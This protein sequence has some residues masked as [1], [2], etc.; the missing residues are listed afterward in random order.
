MLKATLSTAKTMKKRRRSSA[1]GHTWRNFSC[2]EE[3]K[4]TVSVNMMIS[5][6][7]T[8]AANLKNTSRSDVLQLYLYDIAFL[9]FMCVKVI[10]LAKISLQIYCHCLRLA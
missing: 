8:S 5:V 3:E 10:S 2:T 6:Y 7:K 9:F 4:E 1:R